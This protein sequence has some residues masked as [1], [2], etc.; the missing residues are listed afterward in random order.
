VEAKRSRRKEKGKRSRR[1]KTSGQAKTVKKKTA[2]VELAPTGSVLANLALSGT[3]STGLAWDKVL[4]IAGDSSSGKTALAA[5]IVAACRHKYGDEFDWEYDDVENGFSFNTVSMYG[6][7]IL[8]PKDPKTGRPRRSST[9]EQ[10]I[11]RMRRRTDEA[12]KRGVK[13]FIYVVDSLDSLSSVEELRA[14]EDEF[15]TYGPNDSDLGEPSKDNKGKGSYNLGK[16][17]GVNRMFR[18][19]TKKVKVPYFTFIVISQIREKIGSFITEYT[20][21]CKRV[22]RFYSSQVIFLKEVDREERYGRATSVAIK[23]SVTKN[24]IALPFRSC[25]LVILFDWGLDDVASCVDFYYDLRTPGGKLKSEGKREGRKKLNVDFD[26]REFDDREDLI[27]YIYENKKQLMI[28]KLASKKWKD[29]E[30]KIATN[31]SSKY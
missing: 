4:N 7:E 26:G 1:K 31:R 16:Q 6:F 5:E 14:A 11:V 21:H 18:V 2:V 19:A 17:K 10:L 9:V 15:T 23:M 20:W 24:K 13:Y 12:F 3:A 29:I 27:E 8:P 28:K 25:Y 22:L 30:Q